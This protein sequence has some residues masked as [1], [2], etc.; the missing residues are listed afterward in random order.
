[1]RGDRPGTNDGA[2]VWFQFTPH[3]RGSTKP[4]SFL[5]SKLPV[6]PACAGIDL[7]RKKV[8][9]FARRLPRMRGDRPEQLCLLPIYK[10]FTPHARG[11]TSFP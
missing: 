3:A 2:S 5:V 1:M 6:Y 8:Y 10:E 11:S 4:N 7:L 9:F